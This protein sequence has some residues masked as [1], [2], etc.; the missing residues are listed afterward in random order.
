MQR[1]TVN[2][3]AQ[4]LCLSPQAVRVH[5]ADGTL[6]IGFVI[7]KKRKTY[8]VFQ[9]KVQEMIKGVNENGNMG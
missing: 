8:T 7:G 9:E 5:M 1:I 2:Q 3:A 6:P 4:M